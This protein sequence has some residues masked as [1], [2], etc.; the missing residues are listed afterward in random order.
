LS[1]GPASLAGAAHIDC[2][3]TSIGTHSSDIVQNPIPQRSLSSSRS[4][5]QLPGPECWVRVSIA[6]S[7]PWLI[8]GN[9]S[10][11]CQTRR[12]TQIE[13]E[14][15]SRSATAASPNAWEPG[16]VGIGPLLYGASNAPAKLA[17]FACLM[18]ILRLV[19]PARRCCRQPGRAS[20]V[21]SRVAA[22]VRSRISCTM[23]SMT[24]RVRGGRFRREG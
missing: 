7:F 20:Q 22:T 14:P 3:E 6:S 4:G 21:S 2:G 1:L 24:N 10:A 8:N 18:A 15:I 9:A 23:K 5:S 11:E 13:E 16:V 12:C 19:R 17:R